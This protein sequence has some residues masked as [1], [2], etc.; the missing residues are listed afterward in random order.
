MGRESKLVPKR[1]KGCNRCPYRTVKVKV[2]EPE[3]I[4]DVRQQGKL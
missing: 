3:K 4:N 2:K 1:L